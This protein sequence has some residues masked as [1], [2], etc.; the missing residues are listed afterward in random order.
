MENKEIVGFPTPMSAIFIQGGKMKE[1]NVRII[2][3]YI[4]LSLGGD[5]TWSYMDNFKIFLEK[6]GIYIEN[7]E[8]NSKI[9]KITF[10]IEKVKL[11]LNLM[12][13]YN[14]GER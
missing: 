4:T 13:R 12:E 10:S 6:N 3:K 14:K 11:F 9:T 2:A 8:E 5:N 7:W 1:N